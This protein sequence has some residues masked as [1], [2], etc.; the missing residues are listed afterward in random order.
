MSGM[1][2]G[3]AGLIRMI[4]EHDSRILREWPSGSP[5]HCCLTEDG[6]C[7]RVRST[8]SGGRDLASPRSACRRG[9]LACR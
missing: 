2:T 6:H 7:M 9:P 3:H 4:R 8:A 1:G 5:T